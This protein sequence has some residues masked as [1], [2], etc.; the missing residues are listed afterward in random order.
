[1]VSRMLISCLKDLEIPNSIV[2]VIAVNVVDNLLVAQGPTKML[3]KHYPSAQYITVM[4][5]TRMVWSQYAD[6]TIIVPSLAPIPVVVLRT[7]L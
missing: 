2:G 6:S 3:F 5:G 1:M 4:V 7:H